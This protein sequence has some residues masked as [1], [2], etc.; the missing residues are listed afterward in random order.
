MY[1]AKGLGR[2]RVMVWSQA[3]REVLAG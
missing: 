3:R 1:V 2:N